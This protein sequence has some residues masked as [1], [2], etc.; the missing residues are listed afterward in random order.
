MP[1]N[2]NEDVHHT[3]A[4]MSRSYSGGGV[5]LIDISTNFDEIRKKIR[6]L[7]RLLKSCV[8]GEA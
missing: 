4:I 1:T 8:M 6:K 3:Q 5:K 7:N 2:I